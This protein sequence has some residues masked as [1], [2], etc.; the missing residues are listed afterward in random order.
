V[1]KYQGNENLQ[2]TI[3]SADYDRAKKQLDN[4]EYFK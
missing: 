1:K 2:A 4:E 3:S